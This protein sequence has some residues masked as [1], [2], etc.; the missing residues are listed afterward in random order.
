[1]LVAGDDG[2]ALVVDQ[3][4]AEMLHAVAVVVARVG[5]DRL[6]ER[7][8]RHVHCDVADGMDADAVPG[9]VIG[10][11]GL[12]QFVLLDA[13]QPLVAGIV[14][15]GLVELG[16]VTGDA[17]V[18]RHLDPADAQP[19]VA[20][21]GLD[22]EVEQALLAD[23]RLDHPDQERDPD[24]QRALVYQL[25]IG[26]DA[27]VVGDDVMDVGD[28]AGEAALGREQDARLHLSVR[29]FRHHVAHKVLG[30]LD[31]LAGRLAGGVELDGAASRRG[32]RRVDAGELQR[33]GVGDGDVGAE[34]DRDRMVRRRGVEVAAVGK[35]LLRHPEVLH[36]R[37]VCDN[38]GAGRLPFGL[39]LDRFDDLRDGADV[40]VEVAA[41]DPVHHGR[42]AVGEMHVRVGQTR[43][44]AAAL[45]VDLFRAR[46]GQR[47]DVA[48]GADRTDAAAPDRD[49]LGARVVGVGRQHGGVGQH[50]IGAQSS[51]AHA[52]SF[53]V[54]E[55]VRE[56]RPRHS[57]VVE[58]GVNL[59][60]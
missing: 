25:L 12:V 9:A 26:A 21:S 51:D 11:H 58:G 29:V 44:H 10:A 55:F 35:A 16:D 14:H 24:R 17:A 5:L 38:P 3:P 20:E 56:H 18:D 41:V 23:R 39:F 47:L 36:W 19:V 31:E 7:A 34:V 42:A 37:A 40:G 54:G 45:Q 28:A 53:Q 46:I 8:Q 43:Q 4:V 2:H 52:V 59:T 49:R 15:I 6:L 60:A 30:T 13:D 1:M 33:L 22:A 57:T 32:R 48:S 27:G 50:Q